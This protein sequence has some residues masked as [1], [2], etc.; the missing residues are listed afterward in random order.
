MSKEP[1][2]VDQRMNEILSLARE[3]EYLTRP[4]ETEEDLD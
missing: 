3:I 2:I 1:S 4:V